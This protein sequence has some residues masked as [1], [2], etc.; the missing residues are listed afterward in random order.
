MF[1][2]GRTNVERA[3]ASVQGEQQKEEGPEQLGDRAVLG[4]H[5][6]FIQKYPHS[7]RQQWPRPRLR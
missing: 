5:F 6:D 2:G 1:Q 4:I 3:Q 7:L